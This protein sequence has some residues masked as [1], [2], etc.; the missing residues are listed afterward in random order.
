MTIKTYVV[1]PN[2]YPHGAGPTKLSLQ[3][4][5]ELSGICDPVWVVEVYQAGNTQNGGNEGANHDETGPG[6]SPG[7]VPRREDTEDVVVFMDSLSKIPSLLR[8]PPVGMGIT[9]LA[10]DGWGVDIASVLS[11]CEG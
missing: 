2:T 6:G 4:I 10:L 11:R 5:L 9:V 1:S 3:T 8:V 7:V